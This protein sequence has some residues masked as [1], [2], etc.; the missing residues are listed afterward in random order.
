MVVRHEPITW[1]EFHHIVETYRLDALGRSPTQE[2]VYRDFKKQLEAKRWDLV[3]HLLMQS[4]HWLP[5][6]FDPHTPS[7]KSVLSVK[8]TD[9]RP[10]ANANDTKIIWNDFPYYYAEPVAHVCVWVKFP[11]EADPHSEIGDISAAMKATVE[12]YVVRTFCEGL[13]IARSDVIW[14]KN[15]TA[16]QSIRALPHVHVAIRLGA[17]NGLKEAVDALIG[18]P[19]RLLEPSGKF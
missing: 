12:R 8:Y 7:E 15:Y 10:F 17:R 14:W 2:R 16:I 5:A 19:G 11:M 6:D 4:L 9:P 3:T 18:T 13:G 1:R